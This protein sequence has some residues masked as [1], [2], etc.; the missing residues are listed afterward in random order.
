MISN[1]DQGCFYDVVWEDLLCKRE[2]EDIHALAQNL[3]VVRGE[4]IHD[5]LKI[6]KSNI[7]WLGYNK[8]TKWVYDKVSNAAKTIN[9]ENFKFE[10]LGTEPFQY[11]EYDSNEL[12]EYGWHIDLL[13]NSQSVRKLSVIILLSDKNDFSGG[14]L[15][16]SP[17]GATPKEL[18][19]KP[20]RM[21]VFPS[22]MP[23][24]VTPVL[25]G[26]RV[27]LVMWLYGRR[28]K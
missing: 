24:C 3:D 14:S 23:H 19:M 11:T 20:G 27:S 4:T 12:A 21:V 16:V 6:R 13:D 7:R 1:D 28:F 15:L 26:K 18:L 10:L 9:D 8:E 5:E 22:W 2:I 25:E 17:T